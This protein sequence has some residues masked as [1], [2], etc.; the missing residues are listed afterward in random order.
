MVIKMMMTIDDDNI[1]DENER[2]DDENERDD[3]R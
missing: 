3:D 2:D 1:I